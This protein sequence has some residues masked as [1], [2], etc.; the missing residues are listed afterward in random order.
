MSDRR[1]AVPPPIH[2]CPACQH[3]QTK[4]QRKLQTGKYGAPNYVCTRANACILGINLSKVDNW[5]AV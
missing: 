5:I 4:V 2:L 3:P 1:Q